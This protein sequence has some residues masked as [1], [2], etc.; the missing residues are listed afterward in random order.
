MGAFE[1]VSNPAPDMFFLFYIAV[2]FYLYLDEGPAYLPG[3][4]KGETSKS[5]ANR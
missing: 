4:Y 3:Q 5:A 2:I 1:W